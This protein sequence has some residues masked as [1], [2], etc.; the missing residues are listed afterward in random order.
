[1]AGEASPALTCPRFKARARRFDM[2]RLICLTG[3]LSVALVCATSPLLAHTEADPYVTDLIAGQ[4]MDAG[5]VM[6]WNDADNLYVKYAT[7][8]DW[9]MEGIKL[10]V[11]ASLEGIPQ[12]RSG[13]PIPGQF[14]Y[15]AGFDCAPETTV[16]IPL[17]WAP[18]TEIYITAMAEV[19]GSPDPD[20][21][22][23]YFFPEGA[24]A[25]GMDFP[26]KNWAM[27]FTYI[28]QEHL[29]IGWA[30]L[31][32]PPT[33]TTEAGT[34]TEPVFGQVW[35][36][37][38]TSI[39][40]PTPG[41]RAQ[42]GFGPE[43]TNPDGHPDWIWAEAAFNVD[44]GNNDE[45]YVELMPTEIG[46]FDYLYR[47]TVDDGADWLYA[48]LDGPI[49]AGDM[50]P[51]PGKLTVVVAPRT[52]T[53]TFHVTV[54]PITPVDSDVIIAGTL[55]LLD[56]GHPD[57]D[58][59]AVALTK[60]ADYE[61]EI[62][63]TGD[64]G[65]YLEYKY[66]LGSWDFVE[67]GA[68]CEEISNRVLTLDYGTDGTQHIYDDVLAWRNLPPCGGTVEVTFNVTVPE[69]TPPDAVVYIAGSL[70]AL[71]GAYPDWD[72]GA[73][74]LTKM[75]D[76]EWTISFTGETGTSVQYKFTLGSWDF[77]EMDSACF[78]IP[79][80]GIILDYGT[81]GTQAVYDTVLNWNGIP[82]CAGLVQVTFNVTVPEGTPAG[83][84]VYIAGNFGGLDSGLPDW[85]PAGIALTQMGPYEWTVTV[86]GPN[87]TTIEYKYT[88]GAWDF[89]EKGAA[90][91]DLVNRSVTVT[92]G[93]QTASDT[94]L[95]WRGVAPCNNG[96]PV[97]ID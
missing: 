14:D 37:G 2:K 90:C 66:T 54:P 79:N 65:T 17:T 33:L 85:D 45:F 49:P 3:V 69:G 81:D 1:M 86:S 16:V 52:V 74:P 91:E 70:S 82:P 6:V 68:A 21:M 25:E 72:P 39:P 35:I 50:P 34:P 67:K 42:A 83:E 22:V 56:G 47:Y 78:D 31:Q 87:A 9:C 23:S 5:D 59:G 80:R 75:S 58:P 8:G 97:L 19:E 40:G 20:A 94:V 26:G 48:D 53:V 7:S 41:L 73:V 18:G 29:V 15:K 4:T 43:G 77:V 12:T 38:V 32:W 44:A 28:V 27:Y 13:N 10:H 63:F 62:T 71:D 95:N 93:S 64:E 96:S 24:W 51:N 88:L 55:S 57:W 46:N 11:A 89:V 61:W 76:Y 30:N 36:D 92:Y 84:V 60:V